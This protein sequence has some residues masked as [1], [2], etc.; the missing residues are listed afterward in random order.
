MEL[1]V[2]VTEI[3]IEIQELKKKLEKEKQTTTA[4][5]N[6]GT[7]TSTLDLHAYQQKQKSLCEFKEQLV[8]LETSIENLLKGIENSRALIANANEKAFNEI[9]KSTCDFFH[10]L[11]PT[12]KVKLEK[13]NNYKENHH[14][15]QQ[16]KE[17][18]GKKKRNTTNKKLVI[19]SDSEMEED[20][21]DE[22]NDEKE[23][24]ENDDKEI[25]P[26]DFGI[27]F[28]VFSESRK[29]SISQLSGGQASILGLS[30]LLA[31][32]SKYFF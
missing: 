23:I 8:V 30:F 32:A 27:E 2:N 13:I 22:E 11:V 28:I 19:N 31:C 14:H 5:K 21:K 25:I 1:E 10:S 12:L 18:N 6:N 29:S 9:N 4:T 17:M 20:E 3:Q 15:Q 26:L 24:E 16:E 7:T